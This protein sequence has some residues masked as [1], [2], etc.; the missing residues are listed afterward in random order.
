ME[1]SLSERCFLYSDP[2][3]TDWQE[4]LILPNMIHVNVRYTVLF[5][6]SSIFWEERLTLQEDTP[7][8]L[9]A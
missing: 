3:A 4:L 5:L 2:M 8:I 7:P 6:A 1:G 9:E